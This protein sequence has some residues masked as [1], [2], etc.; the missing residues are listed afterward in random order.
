MTSTENYSRNIKAV[1]F[2]LGTSNVH[3][4]RN[5]NTE[6]LLASVSFC[7]KTFESGPEGLARDTH[8]SHVILTLLIR[9]VGVDD[10]YLR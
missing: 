5:S 9:L 6:T 3:H 1:F 4:K 2:K 8:G 10:P 7:D